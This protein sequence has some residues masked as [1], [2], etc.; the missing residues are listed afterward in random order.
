MNR[1]DKVEFL[2]QF[3]ERMH[4]APFVVLADYRGVTANDVNELRRK[5]EER[6]LKFEVVKNTLAR[7]AIAG[8]DKQPLSD[9]FVGMTGVIVSGE[10]PIAAAKAVKECLDPKGKVQVKAGY[11][12]GDILDAAGVA[13]VAS[14]PG[15]EELLVML[16]QTLLAAPRQVMGI[17]RAPA[18][19]LLYLLKN[20]ET[21]L[22]EQEEGE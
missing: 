5:L 21:K 11:F 7:K 17:V 22:A 6:D 1:A 4:A 15:R 18:R 14:L 12:E 2:E 9:H 10:D 3:T 8:S 16:L 13:A 19:D 20:Y